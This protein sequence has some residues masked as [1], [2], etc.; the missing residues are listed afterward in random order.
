MG[1][2]TAIEEHL[3]TLY[4]TPGVL[5]AAVLL[6]FGVGVAHSLAPGHGK[7]ISAAYLVAEGARPRDAVLLGGVVAGMHTLS[8]TVLA[9]AWAAIGATSGFATEVVTGW[10]QVG[11]AAVV[12]V[13]GV[14]LVR[15]R[16][17][18]GGSHHHGHHGG[19][20]HH[21]HHHGPEAAPT[22]SRGMI[23]AL[24]ASGGLLPSPAAFLV[25]VS[26]L[27]SGRT[28]YALGL[29]AAFAAGMAAT[30][31]A[32]GLATLRGRDLLARVPHGGGGRLAA[33]RARLPALSAAA[34][35]V[36][37]LVYLGASIHALPV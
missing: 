8:V 17:R 4:D 1:S 33:F 29:V 19:H 9:V 16:W 30:L 27:L 31:S 32:I 18:R 6:A 2:M 25:L 7:A 23:V 37:G 24:G 5:I 10:L 15:R 26:G 12:V 20:D 13:I 21:H 28:V 11:A 22:T 14:V 36:G 34:V 35:L 3:I